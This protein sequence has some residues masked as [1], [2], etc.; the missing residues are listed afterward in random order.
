MINLLY[1]HIN[2]SHQGIFSGQKSYMH[3]LDV[4]GTRVTGPFADRRGMLN[5]N[6]SVRTFKIVSSTVPSNTFP[7]HTSISFYEIL[8]LSIARD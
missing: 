7:L 2:V 6:D 4:G 5:H 3:A 8:F 1:S